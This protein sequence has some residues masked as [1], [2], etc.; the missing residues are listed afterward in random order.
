[1]IEKDSGL[2]KLK[3]NILRE[4]EITKEIISLSEELGKAK[5]YEERKI[6]LTHILDL[7]NSVRDSISESAEILK[8]INIAKPLQV[9]VEKLNLQRETAIKEKRKKDGIS[10]LERETVKRIKRKEERILYKKIKNP[11]KYIEIASRIFSKTSAKLIKQN[12]FRGLERDLI[13]ANLQFVSTNYVSVMLFTTLLSFIFSF[14]VF[15]FFMFFSLSLEPPFIIRASEEILIRIAKFLFVLVII[16]AATYFAVYFYP[17]LERRSA[18][19]KINQELPFATI[20]MAAISTSMI[21][22][23]TLFK[24]IISTKE[25]PSLEKEFIKLINEVNVYGFDLT[26]A[27][28][29]IAYYSPSAKL[30]ELFNGLA[31]T[32]NS[33]G[34]LPEFF[35]KRSQTLL[36]EYRLEREKYTKSVETFMDIYISIV[37]AAPMVLMLLLMLMGM[38]GFGLTLSTTAITLIIIIV[39]SVINFV[40]IMF[41]QF[42]QPTL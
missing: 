18:E 26:S 2:P 30:T 28:K 31:T 21:D 23:T 9:E 37:I 12:K 36:F 17:A 22:P 29:N 16:P 24:I 34:S 32:I 11:S 15:I 19:N 5:T 35:E 27:L 38:S 6:L 1:M 3:G 13:R 14:F 40:F 7:K 4:K 8:N 41:L 33:G 20:H 10:N 25:Y 39:V 42:K